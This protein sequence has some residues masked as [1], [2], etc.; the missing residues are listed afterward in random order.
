MDQRSGWRIRR[1][2]GDVPSVVQA[3]WID[4]SRRPHRWP[5]RRQ[6]DGSRCACCDGVTT[7]EYTAREI[8]AR[9]SRA[10]RVLD[11]ICLRSPARSCGETSTSTLASRQRHS[12]CSSIAGCQ[13]VGMLQEVAPLPAHELQTMLAAYP[14]HP[15]V[16]V[17]PPWRPSTSTTRS[18]IET[19]RRHQRPRQGR[20]VHTSIPAATSFTRSRGFP[21]RSEH[22]MSLNASPTGRR[23]NARHLL[24]AS[25]TPNPTN[26]APDARVSFEPADGFSRNRRLITEQP[27]EDG[28]HIVPVVMNSAPRNRNTES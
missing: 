20:A 18:A 7:V 6:D 24:I 1:L 23:V 16:F 3:W 11:R 27:G 14:F 10:V 8:I 19:C 12:G 2:Q 25:F 26:I 21:S 4:A 15:S 22:S 28:H 17:F 5:G 13:R 9:G